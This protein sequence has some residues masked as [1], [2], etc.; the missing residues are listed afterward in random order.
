MYV[1]HKD[2]LFH[3]WIPEKCLF[4]LGDQRRKL[5][6][7]RGCK[8]VILTC[9]RQPLDASNEFINILDR[10][11]LKIAAQPMKLRF[12]SFS[13]LALYCFLI[14]FFLHST[15]LCNTHISRN[16][17]FNSN[18]D[19]LQ[20]SCITRAIL[21]RGVLTRRRRLRNYAASFLL[22]GHQRGNTA[23]KI[24]MF[25]SELEFIS[26]DSKDL[27]FSFFVLLSI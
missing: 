13:S 12:L 17:L 19:L 6:V 14:F 1:L 5:E 3:P 21:K 25:T 15:S 23:K 22:C 9:N 4:L 27:R 2:H 18:L 11:R 16:Y 7:G 8:G 26:K 10:V 20:L 24:Y